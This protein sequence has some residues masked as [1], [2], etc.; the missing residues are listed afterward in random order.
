MKRYD[1]KSNPNQL[2]CYDGI[3]E[4]EDGPY[5]AITDIERLIQA[6]KAT[7]TMF[8]VTFPQINFKDSFLSAD[9]ITAWNEAGVQVKLAMD[10]IKE[11]F[12]EE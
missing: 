1:I 5:V 12:G 10:L 9:G 6:V 4:S 2:G 11:Q 8:D 3:V 7:Q